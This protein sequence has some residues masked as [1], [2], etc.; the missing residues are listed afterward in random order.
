MHGVNYYFVSLEEFQRKIENDEFIEYCKVHNNMYGTEKAQI[1][2]FSKNNI[3]PLLD[4]DIQGAKKVYAAF[5]DSNFIFICPPSFKILKERLLFRG[6][7]TEE[8]LKIRMKN[9]ITETQE[10]LELSKVI[11]HRV[12]NDNLEVASQSFINIVEALYLKE[13]ELNSW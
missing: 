9:A 7:E 3:I 8:S 4:I 5:P 12:I 13:L 10:C 1:A 2:E 11:Q 6:T